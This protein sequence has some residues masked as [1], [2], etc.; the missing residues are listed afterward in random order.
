MQY[1]TNKY[2]QKMTIFLS[3]GHN[4]K[5]QKTDSGAIANGYVEAN[6]NIEFKQ[7]ILNE[8]KKSN[9]K[10]IQDYDHES[11]LQYLQR[12]ITGSGSVTL[13][14]HFDAAINP[15]ATGSTSIIASKHTIQSKQFAQ[16]LVDTTSKILQI[17]NRSVITEL[18]TT[19]KKIALVQKKGITALLEIC[20]ITNKNDMLQYQNNK[21]ALAKELAKIIIK[22]ENLN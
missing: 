3:S 13:E 19:R 10:V 15:L 21:I 17:K 2:Y 18:Q 6:L 9:V 22:Y 8:L 1:R 16:E 12:I 11:L 7:L 20:F 5:G 4:P 14:I